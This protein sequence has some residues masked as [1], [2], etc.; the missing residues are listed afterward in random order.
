MLPIYTCGTTLND[1]TLHSYT[2]VPALTIP[3]EGVH[4]SSFANLNEA[5][6]AESSKLTSMTVNMGVCSYLKAALPRILSISAP[7]ISKYMSRLY[8]RRVMLAQTMA[9]KY[10]AHT[11][12]NTSATVE[13]PGCCC[14]LHALG[15]VSAYPTE[16]IPPAAPNRPRRSY[17]EAMLESTPALKCDTI[18]LV[19]FKKTVRRAVTTGVIRRTGRSM[20]AMPARKKYNARRSCSPGSVEK[21]REELT[22]LSTATCCGGLGGRS[23]TLPSIC[24]SWARVKA[25]WVGGVDAEVVLCMTIW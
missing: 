23:T 3:P 1:S 22:Y 6:N 20:T 16:N 7:L 13:P 5:L 15:C 8:M 19:R 2:H 18:C 21:E 11:Q 9:A 4:P 14:V 10:P 12:M 25:G 24:S 17:T